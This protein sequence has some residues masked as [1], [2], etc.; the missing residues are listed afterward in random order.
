MPRKSSRGSPRDL[1]VGVQCIMARTITETAVKI[2]PAGL[3]GDLVCQRSQT[4]LFSSL[5]AAAAA[6]IAPGIVMWPAC[7]TK[8]ALARCCSIC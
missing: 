7:F 1:P 4:G 2:P 5:T 3:S 8:V 6:G